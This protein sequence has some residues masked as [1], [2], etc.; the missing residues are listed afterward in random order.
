MSKALHTLLDGVLVDDLIDTSVPI[1]Q[2]NSNASVEE[3]FK[4]IDEGGVL[5]VPI[6][7][8]PTQSY[9]GLVDTADFLKWIVSCYYRKNENGNSD[10][11]M[12][13]GANLFLHEKIGNI[14]D[15]SKQ[16]PFVPV[17]LGTPLSDAIVC[18]AEGIHRLP[19]VSKDVSKIV[20]IISHS[21]VIKYISEH[22]QLLGDI[23]EEPALQLFPQKHPLVTVSMDETLIDACAKM[24]KFQISAVPIIDF[25]NMMIATLSCSDLKSLIYLSPHNLNQTLLHSVRMFLNHDHDDDINVR[26]PAIG[27][28]DS[29]TILTCI[30]KLKGL[31]IHRVWCFRDNTWIVDGVITLTDVIQYLKGKL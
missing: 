25:S 31:K 22:P 24:V 9:I 20:G 7:D 8:I 1:L 2:V 23:A 17:P 30:A 11:L 26:A 3:A 18:L 21:G 28:T 15:I 4:I 14:S 27:I 12:K 13:I 6:W 19:I 5:S 29:D 16:N 10:C